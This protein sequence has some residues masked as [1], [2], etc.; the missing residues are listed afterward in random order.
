MLYIPRGW[1]H[2]AAP[3]MGEPTFHLAIGAHTA[4]LVDYLVWIA[5]EVLPMNQ[6]GK[7]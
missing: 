1:W 5:N 4:K 2:E 7:R 3:L 6:L